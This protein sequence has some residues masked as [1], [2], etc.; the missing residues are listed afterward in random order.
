MYCA[1]KV[2]AVLN[3]SFEESKRVDEFCH[4]QTPAISFIRAE[5]R[6]L[7]GNIFCDFGPGFVVVD[8]DG[9]TNVINCVQY[10]PHT[11]F[12]GPLSATFLREFKLALAPS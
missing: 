2:V 9:K 12:L 10:W 7:F 1:L 11:S 4:Q 5:T 3:M 8:V 6:G